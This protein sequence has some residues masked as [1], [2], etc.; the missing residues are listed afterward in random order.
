MSSPSRLIRALL[1]A[2]AAVTLAACGA[3]SP[4]AGSGSS[5]S[6]VD[7]AGAKQA[8]LTLF[9]QVDSNTNVWIPCPSSDGY[10]TCPLSAAVKD[11]LVALDRANY[12]YSGPGGRC[13]GDFISNSTNGLQKEPSV[14][15][16][17]AGSNGTVTVVIERANT[18][19]PNLTAVMSRE[20]QRWVAIDLQSGSGPSASVFATNP[21]C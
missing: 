15:S 19:I 9:V 17:V 2:S 8:A 6:A 14:I 11:R 16:A 3:A 4:P 13:A 20:D 18:S 5:H 12:F 10:A 21:N 1:S 7:V